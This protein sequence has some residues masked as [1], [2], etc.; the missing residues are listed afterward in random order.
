MVGPRIE[1]RT[2]WSTIGPV[3]LSASCIITFELYMWVSLIHL[4]LPNPFYSMQIKCKYLNV[5]KFGISLNA[6][7]ILDGRLISSISNMH[8]ES[9]KGGSRGRLK[10]KGTIAD[11]AD[12]ESSTAAS[13]A[14]TR[15][16]SDG[17]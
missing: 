8:I 9:K 2:W 14:K 1:Q 5:W 12:G 6:T 17:R 10:F 7:T 4:H 16:R 13:R 15:S 3:D 11:F